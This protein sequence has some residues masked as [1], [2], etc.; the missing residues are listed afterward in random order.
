MT[1]WTAIA[2]WLLTEGAYGAHDLKFPAEFKF[3]AATAA[4]QVEGAWNVSGKTPSAWDTLTHTRPHVIA[5]G[6]TGD[7][8]CDSYH[9]WKDDIQ[10]AADLGLDFYRFSISWTRVLPTG[11]PDYINEDGRRYYDNLIN[12]LLEKGIEPVVTMHHFDIPQ[13]LQDLGGWS[14]PLISDW[15]ADYARVLYQLFG[16]RVKTWITIN[17]PFSICT[18]GYALG[19]FSAGVTDYEVG[20]YLCIKNVVLAHSKAWRIYDQEFRKE[21][22]GRVGVAHQ[23]MYLEPA[24]KADEE[25]AAL[26]HEYFYGLYAHP[27]FSKDGG[28]PPGIEKVIAK[29]SEIQGYPRSR[30]PA[31]TDEE[32][33]LAKGAYGFFGLNYYTSRKVRRLRV[34]ESLGTSSPLRNIGELD[35]MF[36]VDPSWEQGACT[37]FYSYPEGMRKQLAWVKEQ[38]G[39]VEVIITENGYSSKG[40][41]LQDYDR[42]KYYREHLEQVLLS[43]HED[44]VNIIGYIAWSLID[45]F[46]WNDGYTAKFGLYEVNFDDPK[47]PRTPRDSAQYYKE[48]IQTHSIVDIPNKYTRITDEL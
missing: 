40:Y 30:L 20:S 27:V 32:K 39:D 45:N 35:A 34:G 18:V 6:S 47:R 2:L 3:G 26:A 13:R 38:Y 36:E 11:F 44:K 17:E 28:W 48:V 42:I 23:L 16:D 4:Y 46:E 24:T 5:D 43:I 8:A 25:I 21:F 14:N 9:H 37:W 33:E 22:K 19:S 1:P 15:F 7:V 12:G 10:I 31:F 29:N 41:N